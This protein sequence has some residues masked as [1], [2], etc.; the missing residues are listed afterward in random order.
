[1]GFNN[2]ITIEAINEDEAITKAKNEVSGVY[3]SKMLNRFSFSNDTTFK[4]Q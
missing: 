3:G 1:M 2:S 4:N